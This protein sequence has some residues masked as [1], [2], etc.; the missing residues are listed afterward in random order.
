[1]IFESRTRRKKKKKSTG[2]SK[3]PSKPLKPDID[4]KICSE[5]EAAL[6]SNLL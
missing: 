4:S 1:V 6:K 2:E 5:R 3:T